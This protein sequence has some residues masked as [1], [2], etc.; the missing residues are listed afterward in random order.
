MDPG[1][2]FPVNVFA[3]WN[4]GVVVG[5]DFLHLQDVLKEHRVD[6]LVGMGS[7]LLCLPD[8]PACFLGIPLVP[9]GPHLLAAHLQAWPLQWG[10][11]SLGYR[12]ASTSLILREGHSGQEVCQ[13][14]KGR[15]LV[16]SSSV[17]S[18][19]KLRTKMGKGLAQGHTASLVRAGDGT[20]ITLKPWLLPR[21][22]LL[23][24]I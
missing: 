19:G 11:L 20:L 4:Q 22:P 14:M 16:S 15:T 17:P 12:P 1:E 21:S 5:L 9:C 7:G 18:G 10:H 13:Q 6:C 3:C 2:H 23:I 8:S 24:S